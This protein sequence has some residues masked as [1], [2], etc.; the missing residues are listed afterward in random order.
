[1]SKYRPR[2]R[3]EAM[4]INLL[5][6]NFIIVKTGRLSQSYEQQNIIINYLIIKFKIQSNHN[7]LVFFFYSL[8]R[9]LEDEKNDFIFFFIPSIVFMFL[10]II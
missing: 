8:L 6:I 5:L 7:I 10:K 1:M 9:F 3:F 4:I 2:M